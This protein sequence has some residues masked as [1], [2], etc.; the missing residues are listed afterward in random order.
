MTIADL[1]LASAFV[2][3]PLV[4]CVMPEILRRADP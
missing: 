1:L 2:V 3:V 4:W